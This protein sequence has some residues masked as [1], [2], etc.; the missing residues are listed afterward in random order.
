MEKEYTLTFES[1]HEI[2]I[3]ETTLYH[4]IEALEDLLK[5]LPRRTD[6][7]QSMHEKLELLEEIERQTGVVIPP[8][9][10]TK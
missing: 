1:W 2:F 9:K 4:R 5:D 8:R 7:R 3:I 6:L 10:S